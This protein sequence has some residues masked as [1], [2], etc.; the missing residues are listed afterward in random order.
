[1]KQRLLIVTLF[2]MSLSSMQA[3]QLT[4]EESI[5]RMRNAAHKAPGVAMTQGQ[6]LT[7][8][9]TSQKMGV[10]R[11]Y[12]FNASNNAG[13]YILGADDLVPGVLGYSDNGA[14]D[15][16][17]IPDG[18]RQ[19]MDVLNKQIDASIAS[20]TPLYSSTED[21]IYSTVDHLITTYWG[22]GGKT[23]SNPFAQD[24]PVIDDQ[25]TYAGCV[26]TAMAMMMHYYKYPEMGTGSVSYVTETNKIEQSAD[27]NTT[28][29]WNLMQDAYGMYSPDGTSNLQE[30]P[31]SPEAGDAVAK[32]MH[33]CGVAVQADYGIKD[34]P[35]PSL[36]IHYAM[37]R[38]FG[39][40]LGVMVRDRSCYT[41]SEWTEL[42]Y[43]ELAEGRP[44]LF[45]AYT[46]K[47]GHCFILDGYDNGF[48]H[49]NWGWSGKANGYYALTG[50]DALHPV[51]QEPDGE[52][53]NDAFIYGQTFFQG[54]QPSIGT[55][56][57]AINFVAKPYMAVPID[58]EGNPISQA[59]NKDG[60]LLV[61]QSE[62]T[63]FMNYTCDDVV[64][65]FGGEFIN[66]ETGESFFI[67]SSERTVAF[68][69]MSGLPMFP[70]LLTGLADG[71]Y[72]VYPAVY[73]EA[74]QW[75]RFS[76]PAG[77]NALISVVNGEQPES[78]ET[79]DVEAG[80]SEVYGVNGVR[81]SHIERGLN[82]VRLPSGKS[83][84]VKK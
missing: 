80:E 1:M 19:W 43:G 31:Y 17:D 55:T 13:F 30:M 34:T 16:N 5:S 26:P 51:L 62:Q 39:Y 46:G 77:T 10:N 58:L 52:P 57:P 81:K 63:T 56:S 47:E 29:D 32:L 71:V 44:A 75:F 20:N 2:F 23:T 21:N 72:R 74:G 40:D 38:Y 70:L 67:D 49:V 48:F 84:K 78:I 42:V 28:Y 68:P 7:L 66:V 50:S 36:D 12:V 41:D 9:Y 59:S 14:F 83:V 76:V 53:M 64:V 24:C 79:V 6:N 61:G 33:H 25:R 82:I 11:F 3:R 69:F 45:G 65:G 54:L 35:A 15:I 27:F 22:Q 73:N 37:T 60:V 8:S 4:A 18:L